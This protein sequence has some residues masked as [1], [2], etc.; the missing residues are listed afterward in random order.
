M[1]RIAALDTGAG[2]CFSRSDPKTVSWTGGVP[3]DIRTAPKPPASCRRRAPHAPAAPPRG[4]SRTGRKR[5]HL[6]EPGPPMPP[7]GKRLRAAGRPYVSSSRRRGRDL[8]PASWSR[9]RTVA[10]GDCG[11]RSPPCRGTRRALPLHKAGAA[12]GAALSPCCRCLGS[13]CHRRQVPESRPPSPAVRTG[14]KS[15]GMCRG[16]RRRIPVPC[17]RG[18]R[19]LPH[20][21]AAGTSWA[22]ALPGMQGPLL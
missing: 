18:G 13:D 22:P 3:F 14:G 7:A 9:R 4:N 12:F 16:G 11:R 10:T 6:P 8:R 1:G 2:C 19:R 20:A 15:A 21:P 17:V 5:R